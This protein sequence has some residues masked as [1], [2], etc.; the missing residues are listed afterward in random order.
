MIGNA[1]GDSNVDS[2]D[3]YKERAEPVLV[4]LSNSYS[5]LDS[6]SIYVSRSSFSLTL[7]FLLTISSTDYCLRER[8]NNFGLRRLFYSK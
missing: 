7:H 2:K 8:V 3:V 6:I 4:S 1:D 5:E